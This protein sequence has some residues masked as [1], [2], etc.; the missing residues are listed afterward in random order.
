MKRG[1]NFFFSF[2]WEEQKKEGGRGGGG[3]L[4]FYSIFRGGKSMLS[5]IHFYFFPTKLG[6]AGI[7]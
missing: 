4:T 3:Q 1:V 7:L 5:A 2:L 6:L